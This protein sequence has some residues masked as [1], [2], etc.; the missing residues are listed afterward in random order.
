MTIVFDPTQLIIQLPEA[1]QQQAWSKSKN[2]A[3]P[4]SRWQSYLNQL[5]LDAFIPCGRE[6][7]EA[8][9]KPWL[10]DQA[11]AN[12]WE[13]VNGTAIMLGDA[14]VVLIP[15]EAEDL[16]EL[17]LPQEWVDIPEWVA[18]YYLAVQVNV[19]AGFLRVWGYTTHQK[20][21]TTATYNSTDRTY[22]LDHNDLITD[23][24]AFWIARELCPEEVTK[25]AVSPIT[26][27]SPTQANNLIQRLGDREILL[28]RLAIPFT[29]WAALLQND[30]WR[31]GLVEGRQGITRVSVLNWLQ[32]EAANLVTEF[33]W[34][35]VEFQPSTVGAKGD[36]ATAI[37]HTALA[38]Q[39][40]IAG[41]PYELKILPLEADIWRFEL[42]NLA[43]GAMI[44]SGFT[45]RLLTEDGQSFEGNEDIAT[46][47]VEM[48]YIEVELEAGEGLIWEIE[49]NPEDYQAEV[50]RF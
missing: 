16:E 29:I 28:P 43:L 7:Q 22:T 40:T 3:T 41:Q 1:L 8:T 13:L 48:L 36:T 46:I 33:G 11:L 19:D 9:V 30:A 38:K 20:V 15:S 23:L 44:P 14:K 24:N 17:R 26:P 47:P 37:P 34:R 5:T 32:E 42:R 31:N 2:A 18:D 25:V 50:L 39:L 12:I 6:E 35:Q 49:P 27:I 45:L 21:K 4:N 10:N